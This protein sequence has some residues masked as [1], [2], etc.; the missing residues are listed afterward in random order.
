MPANGVP[1]RRLRT[2]RRTPLEQAPSVGARWLPVSG[3]REL[4]V[5]NLP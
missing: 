4:A 5:K 1:G 2:Q 3:V